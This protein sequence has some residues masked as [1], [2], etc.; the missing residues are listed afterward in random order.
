[1]LDERGSQRYTYTGVLIVVF[2]CVGLV[3]L[4]VCSGAAYSGIFAANKRTAEVRLEHIESVFLLAETVAQA[5][6]VQPSASDEELY[7]RSYEH[8]DNGGL[9]E[10]ERFVL[11]EMNNHFGAQRD[12]DFTVRRYED[13]DGSHLEISYF[14][15]R[16]VEN[17][18]SFSHFISMNGVVYEK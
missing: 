2:I 6:E 16:D 9:S 3:I 10:Y 17:P 15:V 7:I 11:N 8:P 12:F 14:P 13:A 1:M 5:N 18:E 4:A